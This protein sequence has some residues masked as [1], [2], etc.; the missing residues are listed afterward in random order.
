[1]VDIAVETGDLV[2][3]LFAMAAKR[4]EVDGAR[5]MPGVGGALKKL[6]ENKLKSQPAPTGQHAP[7]ERKE[8]PWSQFWGQVA[9]L[10]LTQD[11]AREKLG[12]KSIKDWT[13]GGG[14][15]ESA[16]AE[17]AAVLAR[18]KTEP[19]RAAAEQRV[20]PVRTEEEFKSTL[21]LLR[22]CSA[23]FNGM[24]STNVFMELGY[25]NQGI[26]EDSLIGRPIE[27]SLFQAYLQI[28]ATKEDQPPEE[29]VEEQ[30]EIPF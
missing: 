5:S 16:I 8:N 20:I 9:Q 7:T 13:D 17:L 10:G 2:H 23:D 14:T 15:R 24:S 26:F 3:T 30:S 11:E 19:A 27:S 1:M 28:K 29:N 12:V 22:I 6:F 18:E 25:A 21:D 4:A